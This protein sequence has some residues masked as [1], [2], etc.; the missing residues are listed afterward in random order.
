MVLALH[1]QGKN[2][3]P[4]QNTDQWHAQTDISFLATSGI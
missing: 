2:P 4:E 3:H 1:H